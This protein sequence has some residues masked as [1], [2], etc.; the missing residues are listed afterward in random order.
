MTWRAHLLCFL[1]GLLGLFFL[2]V[3]QAQDRIPI[4]VMIVSCFEVGNDTGD[5][6]GEFQFFAEREHLTQAIPVPGAPH[7]LVHN[8]QGLYGEVA[9]VVN[10]TPGAAPDHLSIV[11]TSELIMALCL[12]P[13]LDLRKTYWIINGIAGVDPATGSIG[14]AAWARHVVDGDAMREIDDTE[15]P[16]GWPYGLFAIGTMKPNTLPLAN[17]RNGGW[18]GAKLT[19][20]M[21]Y[22]LNPKLAQWAYAT[23]RNIQLPD[24]DALRAFR[25][26][27]TGFPAAQEPP[28][29]IMG[30]TLGTA[31]YWHGPKRTQW[32][33]DWVKLWT[34]G[35]GT[36]CTTAME[37]QDYMYTL[38]DMA[39]KGFLDINRVLM[40]RGA[41]NYC[42][43]P[44]GQSIESTIGDESLGTVPAFEA[45]Y[46]AATA[47]AHALLK[48]WAEAKD[49]I[50]GDRAAN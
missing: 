32:A 8:D 23:S 19:Y 17:T 40:I 28:H 42:M 36:L 37:H 31:R 30:D 29:I 38:T 39:K 12:D 9:G 21:D 2:P 46:Q 43:P 49:H 48:N 25:A 5:T 24:S 14:S 11:G 26:K 10:V 45:D 22:A 15:I 33:R 35:Q 3:V 27:Y 7:P 1:P 18:G 44:P 34:N 20:I 47:V 41:S 16:A 13:K 4:K 6:P 50:P